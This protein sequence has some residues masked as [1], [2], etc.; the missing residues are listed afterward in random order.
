MVRA[1]MAA[2]WPTPNRVDDL[3]VRRKWVPT[4]KRPSMTVLA[5]SIWIGK[6]VRAE[7]IDACAY[8]QCVTVAVPHE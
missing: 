3:R 6:P 5:P 7:R 8:E 4:K 2:S 1:T